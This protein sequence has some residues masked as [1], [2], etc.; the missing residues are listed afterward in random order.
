MPV[1]DTVTTLHGTADAP[2]LVSREFSE[3]TG[4]LTFRTALEGAHLR[5]KSSGSGGDQG[6]FRLREPT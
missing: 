4:L 3:S 5:G 2:G 1:R 6:W